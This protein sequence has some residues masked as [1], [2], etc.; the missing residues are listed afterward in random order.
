M[1]RELVAEQ[2]ISLGS[3][4]VL[5]NLARAPGRRLRMAELA[6]AVILSRSGITRLVDRLERLGWV[7]RQRVVG[8]GRGVVA[9]LTP[10]GLDTLRRAAV[11]HL[12]GISRHFVDRFDHDELVQ[13]GELCR[14]L[15]EVP[16]GDEEPE[17][18]G[19]VVPPAVPSH[20]IGGTCAGSVPDR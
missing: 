11:T 7:S 14:R 5:V 20:A 18:G 1:E 9:A 6:D 15:M 2:N 10:A 3:Y 13:V 16:D 8:D 17:S 19:R 4:D 12:A